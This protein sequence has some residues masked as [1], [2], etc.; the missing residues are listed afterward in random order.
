MDSIIMLFMNSIDFCELAGSNPGN[1]LLKACLVCALFC[2]AFCP[3]LGKEGTEFILEL[4]YSGDELV[5][6]AE[7]LSDSRLFYFI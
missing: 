5:N 3:T 4:N 7:S 1:A 2:V 6:P